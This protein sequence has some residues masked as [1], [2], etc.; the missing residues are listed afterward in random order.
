MFEPY[1]ALVRVTI[2]ASRKAAES[3]RGSFL[4]FVEYES[5]RD[6]KGALENMND[7][8]LSGRVNPKKKNIYIRWLSPSIHCI[9]SSFVSLSFVSVLK[10]D[11]ACGIFATT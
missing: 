10:I 4:A 3:S 2:S 1:G 8:V 7:F 6:A 11:S 9:L 5:I